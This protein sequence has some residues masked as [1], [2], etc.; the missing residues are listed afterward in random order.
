MSFYTLLKQLK[1]HG[2]G[3]KSLMVAC[4]FVSEDLEAVQDGLS[5]PDSNRVHLLH[6]E[7]QT[8]I[9]VPEPYLISKVIFFFCFFCYQS[10]AT[11]IEKLYFV[12]KPPQWD[13]ARPRFHAP[14]LIFLCCTRDLYIVVV[15]R[16]VFVQVYLW[17]I[18]GLGIQWIN[19]K[20]TTCLM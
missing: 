13:K 12:Q 18:W 10:S 4:T 7:S 1:D 5:L 2:C 3:N 17:H 20:L 9:Q 16:D 6:L 11:A 14:N 19:K 8:L 15:I